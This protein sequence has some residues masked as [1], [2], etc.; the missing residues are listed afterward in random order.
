MASKKINGHGVD[1][2]KIVPEKTVVILKNG[3]NSV[4]ERL[5]HSIDI[6]K[7]RILV[8]SGV[9]TD[10]S[11]STDRKNVLDMWHT[12]NIRQIKK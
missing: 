10:L 4:Q 2:T 12:G 5:V 11:Y 6:D 3:A 1:L 7:Q 9:I 8:Y